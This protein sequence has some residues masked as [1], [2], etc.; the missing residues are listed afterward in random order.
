MQRFSSISA[1]LVIMLMM[2]LAFFVPAGF[3]QQSP[4]TL[5]QTNVEP[6]SLVAGATGNVTVSFTTAN[7]LPLDGKVVVIFPAGFNVASAAGA[8]CSTM[9]GGFATSVSGQSVTISRS[10]GTSQS[11]AAETCL[12]SNIKNPVV[13]GPTGTYSLKTTSSADVVIDQDL[14]VPSDTLAP[15][16]LP[17]SK[18]LLTNPVANA[19]EKVYVFFQTS[20]PIPSDG[21]I[22][23]TFP[24][25]F[26]LSQ[27]QGATCYT[28]DGTVAASSSGQ[29]LT[30]TRSGGTAQSAD[31]E[32]CGVDNVKNPPQ[33]GETGSFTIETVTASG[34]LIDQKANVA[35][36]KI[37][38]PKPE[39][40]Q[41]EDDHGR[42]QDHENRSYRSRRDCAHMKNKS[43]KFSCFDQ[44]KDELKAEL[45]ASKLLKQRGRK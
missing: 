23:I 1:S 8:T 29:V 42:D 3:A 22:K 25:G 13:S 38:A 24:S 43:D 12:M 28:M 33:A 2:T 15:G 37:R 11:A 27:A 18:I 45:N 30:L 10:G 44:K 19:L 21:K 5:T 41:D 39:K 7:V 36:E 6:V 4:G 31:F 34:V 14:A 26:D 9:D 35:G 16:T 20:N 17:F 40:D 32:L